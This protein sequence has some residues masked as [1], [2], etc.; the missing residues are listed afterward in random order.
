MCAEPGAKVLCELVHLGAIACKDGAVDD[1][2]GKDTKGA[3][4][5]EQDGVVVLLGEAVVLE[6]DTGVGIDVREGVLGLAVLGEDTRSDLVDLGDEVEHG[7]LGEVL[8]SELA[9]ADVAGVGLAEDGVAVTGNDTA[10]VEGVPEVLLD[11]L[12]RE[13]RADAG[14]HL[15]EPVE[16]LLVGKTVERTSETI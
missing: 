8:E 12:V 3:G 9:L 11:V 1:E 13:V 7:V 5:A 15:G 14:L 4:N 10:G 2:L 6:E 16:D